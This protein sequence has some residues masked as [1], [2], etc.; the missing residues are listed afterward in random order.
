[1]TALRD[2]LAKEVQRLTYRGLA[3]KTGISRGALESLIKPKKGESVDYPKIETLI[4]LSKAYDKPLWK[5]MEMAE[6]ELDLPQTADEAGRRLGQLI[7][8]VPRLAELFDRIMARW[9]TDPDFVKGF[10]VGLEARVN[11]ANGPRQ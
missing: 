1:M 2:F 11:G 3:D 8:Q 5:I 10:I 4:R 6:I 7:V 9:D